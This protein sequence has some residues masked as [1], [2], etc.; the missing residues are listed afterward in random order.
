MLISFLEDDTGEVFLGTGTD[1]L[2][3]QKIDALLCISQL[4]YLLGRL[5]QVDLR[6][7]SLPSLL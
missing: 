6:A 3:L 1:G 5:R 4:P 2:H 7:L